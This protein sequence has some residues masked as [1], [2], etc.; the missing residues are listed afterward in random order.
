MKKSIADIYGIPAIVYNE[1]IN[2]LTYY[3]NNININDY[4]KIK[5]NLRKFTDKQIEKNKY[6]LKNLI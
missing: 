4:I 3:I 5:Y 6:I 2:E 1:T